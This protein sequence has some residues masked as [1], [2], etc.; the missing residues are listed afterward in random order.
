M[1][2]VGRWVADNP[3]KIIAVTLVITVALGIFIPGINMVTDFREYLSSSNEAVKVTTEA[4]EKYGSASYIQ[5]SIKP[6]DTIFETDVLRRIN[7]LREN[8]SGLSGVKSVE[9]PLNSQIIVGKEKSIE[10]GPAAPGGE[11]PEG[12]SEMETY[13][14]KL[15]S[16]KLLQNRVVSESGDAAALSVELKTDVNSKDVATE[17]RNIVA[18]YEGPEEIELAGQPY[19]NSAFS[20]A[21]TNDLKILL[22]LVFLAIIIVLYITFRSPRGVFLPL[23]VVALS[24][25]WT[26]GL[27]SLTG[28]PFTM[29]SFILPV[30]LAAV[31]SAY[32]IHVLNS[33]YEWS[34]KALS[35]KDTIVETVTSMYSPVAM[36]GLTTAAGFLSLVSAFLI[37]QRH[38]GIF[39]AIGVMIAVLL[40]LT[41]VPAILSLLSLQEKKQLPGFLSFTGSATNSLIRSFTRLIAKRNK[42]VVSIFAV[43]LIVFIVGTMTIQVNTSYTAI[44]GENNKMTLGMNSMDENFAGSQ[45]LL[46]EIDTGRKNGLKEPEV[47]KKMEEFQEWLKSKEGL[48]VNKTASIVDIVK[49]LN[50]K[51]HGGN[52]DYYRVPD[53]QQLTSQL[54]LLFSFQGGSMGRLSLG[55]FSAGEITGLYDQA[56]SSE[57]NEL[58]KSVNNYLDENF[59]SLEARMVGS[60]MIQQEMSDKVVSSQIISLVTTI[61]VAGLI[62]AVIMRSLTAG[63]ISLVPLVSAVA[64]N[65][66][67]MGFAGIPLNLVNL[68]VSSIMIGIGIDYAIHLLERFQEE[69]REGRDRLEIFSTVLST[70]GKGIFANAMA[71]ALGFS[72]IG[73]STFSSITTV[74]FLLAMAM[75]VSMI[76][77]FTVIPAIL[78]LLKP[79]MLDK[80]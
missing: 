3:W 28:V 17:I 12:S 55:D 52:P 53:N 45:Q 76:S 15:L 30:I 56:T 47:L 38:F 22:P 48:Q 40:S 71:L 66:G 79:K 59:P 57:M 4:E 43:I 49:E 64:I 72:V 19:F 6:E 50:Q 39:A 33:Y 20:E 35:K 54:L 74:G 77:T 41:L 75:V 69:Y 26:V 29:V 61:L 7:E 73:L 24:I 34:E 16:S 10:V 14:E 42:L 1:N 25:T 31:G 23:L 2:S 65:F 21:I 67:I 5:V 68:I 13:R 62:V 58:V 36:T 44:I 9:G 8:I 18:D 70:T 27:M 60:T 63:V 80:E 37:P 46:V 32:S 11:V 51:F 78:F